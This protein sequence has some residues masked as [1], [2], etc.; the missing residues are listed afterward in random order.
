MTTADH[1][2]LEA[3]ATPTDYAQAEWPPRGADRPKRPVE[4]PPVLCCDAQRNRLGLLLRGGW[5][6]AL[7]LTELAA[8]VDQQC[9]G[10]RV[11]GRV[12]GA[13]CQLTVRIGDA[14]ELRLSLYAV[15]AAAAVPEGCFDSLWLTITPAGDA[16]ASVDLATMLDFVHQLADGLRK[17]GKDLA[18]SPW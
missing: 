11:S 6:T 9:T 14:A 5:T 15:A 3:V 16:A 4:Q 17:A 8:V 2:L 18:A 12:G 13:A 1:P 7:P 10:A